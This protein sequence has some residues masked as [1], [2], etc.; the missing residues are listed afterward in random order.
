MTWMTKLFG[1]PNAREVA[2]IRS[3][4][5]RISALEPSVVD[6]SDEALKAKT[7]EFRERLA[8]GETVEAMLVEAF[9]VVREVSQRVL[10]QRQYDVQM[11]GGLALHQGMIAE[12]RTGEGKTLTATAPVY[13][14]ALTGKG[15]HVVTVNDYLA[16]RDA[17]WMGQV[18]AALGLTVGCVQHA[19]SFLYD[20]TFKN[21]PEHDPERDATGSFRVDMDY[22]RP[23]SRREA[24][25]ADITYGTNN[26]FG[27]DFLRDNMVTRPEEMVQRELHYAVVDEVDSI[28]IDEARTP[29][30]ISAPAAE[31]TDAYYKYAD[32]V[33]KLVKEEDYK[34]DEKLRSSTLTEAGISKLEQWLGV[35]NL[36][37]QGGIKTVHHIEQALRAMA[38]YH[39]DREYVVRDGE[40]VI[41]DEFTGRMMQGRRYSEGLHQAIEAKERVPIQR[42]S[43]TLATVTFQNYFRLYEKLSGMTGTAV[44]EAEEFH[45]IYK[46]EV[47]S[48]PTNRPNRRTDL[49]DRVYQN[50]IGKFKAV[51]SE[52]KARHEKGQPVLVGTVSIEKNELL[53]EMLRQAG[54]PH[55]VLNAKNHEKEAEIIA[56]AGRKGAVTVA[57]NM[58]GRGVDIILGGNPP[59]EAMTEEIRA[60]GGLHVLGTE[61]HESRRID[62]QLRGRAGRQGDPGTTQFYLS[63]EDD[64]MRIFGKSSQRVK[65][66]MAG[67]KIPDDEP[68]ENGVL[69]KQLAA[70]QKKVEGH[71]FDIRKHLLEYDDVINKHRTVIYKKRR[72]ILQAATKATE[73]G[74][75]P[76]QPIIIEMIEGEVEQL[77]SFH[78]SAEDTREWGMDKIEDGARA[79]LP[80][81]FDVKAS[82]E[83]ALE[84]VTDPDDFIARRTAIIEGIMK[85][86]HEA[87]DMLSDTLGD[88]ALQ[89]EIEK[90]VALRSID[91]L[92]ISHLEAID[93]LRH[94]VGLQGYGQRDPLVEYK[95]EAYRLFQHMLATLN[96][97]VAHMLFKVQVTKQQAEQELRRMQP[98][99]QPVQLS[100][101]AKTSDELS[102]ASRKTESD[103]KFDKVGRNDPCPCGSGKKYKKCHGANV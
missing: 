51:V 79:I 66:I 61:R 77:V 75:S 102:G 94:G 78:T 8:K 21:E 63:M 55:Q 99:A 57:T 80:S 9:A 10:K 47:L 59:D 33:A 70:A 3:V 64:L 69:T 88:T 25:H 85:L 20:P 5:D 91:D 13:L 26:E 50:Q 18:Y 73:E 12:M 22:M 95:R 82:V 37:I 97:R 14:N 49:P 53:S 42:E 39:K 67:L 68:I 58:A 34:V 41:V 96:Q 1:D 40:V 54:V 60:L 30:I 52:I 24:Y 31:A 93:Y 17:I 43:V 11:I 98:L 81:G 76:L 38:L 87:Y 86:V 19:G 2:K 27:F 44:T 72:D 74:K 29:L 101:A 56:Q 4:V 46:L 23:V 32:L 103:P 89:M 92:W 62:N 16:R 36:Y 28:L 65:S 100:G 6:L 90:V 45:K 83:A 48:I 84:T 71:N 35:E 7:A 15:V